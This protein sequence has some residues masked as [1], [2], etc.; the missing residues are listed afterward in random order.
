MT[1]IEEYLGTVVVGDCRILAPRL[2]DNC[3]VLVFADPPY[4]VGFDY[5]DKTDEDME[6]IDP[7]WLVTELKRIAQVVLITPGITN[8][9]DYPKADWV[10]AWNKPASTGR[11]ETLKGFNVWEPILVYGE[12]SKRVW[13]DSV[14]AHGGRE[15]DAAFHKCPKPLA[16]LSWIVEQFTNEGDLVIDPLSGSGTTGKACRLL[17]RD[18]IGFELNPEMARLANERIA[19]AQPPLLTANTEQ[20]ELE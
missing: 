7:I 11:S 20:L 8:Y 10:I 18:F 1:F 12:P 17:R 6:K 4:W 5:G 13:Q 19:N 15:F 3:A 16:L 14:T 2:P 9:H